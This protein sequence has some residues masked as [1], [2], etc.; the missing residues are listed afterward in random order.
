[1]GLDSSCYNWYIH[2]NYSMCIMLYFI[3]LLSFVPTVR[4]TLTGTAIFVVVTLAAVLCYRCSLLRRR[5]NNIGSSRSTVCA[6][7]VIV[8][9][10]NHRAAAAP[11]SFQPSFHTRS[12][13]RITSD[14]PLLDYMN[15]KTPS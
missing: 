13:H 3:L 10:V 1:M 9:G 15:E 7:V 8:P 2:S 11:P 14:G 12:V 5:R 4:H 6:V